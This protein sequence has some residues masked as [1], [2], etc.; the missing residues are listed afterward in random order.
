MNDL[1]LSRFGFYAQASLLSVLET[2]AECVAGRFAAIMGYVPV[3]SKDWNIVPKYDATFTS[4]FDTLKLYQRK[5]MALE[6][7]TFDMLAEAIAREPKLSALS[8]DALVALFTLR[9]DLKACERAKP[10][11]TLPS[12][13]V[14]PLACESTIR[15]S[16]V[17]MV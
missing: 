8:H 5:R 4:R 15:R 14:C 16:R 17:T 9:K 6:G 12:S 13:K 7:I 1:T 11:A 3:S 10:A 2:L